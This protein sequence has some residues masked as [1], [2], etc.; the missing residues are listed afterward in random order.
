MSGKAAGI[1]TA[2]GWAAGRW[3]PGPET[4]GVTMALVRGGLG[5]SPA[6]A[7]GG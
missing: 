5:G 2:G 1:A 7:A 6:M 3:A 4:P